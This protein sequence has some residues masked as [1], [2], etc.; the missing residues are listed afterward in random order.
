MKDNLATITL[1]VFLLVTEYSN[2]LKCE[3][4][5]F[6]SPFVLPNQRGKKKI[7]ETWENGI[8]MNVSIKIN[9]QFT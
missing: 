5:S 2:F 7:I 4:K 1:F 8:E 3:L 9:I 6:F